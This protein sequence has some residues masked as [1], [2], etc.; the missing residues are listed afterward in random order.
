MTGCA[1]AGNAIVIEDAGGEDAWGMAGATIV[2]GGH[3]IQRL[4]NRG[5][6]I[7]AGFAQFVYHARDSVVE[8]FRPGEG[9]GVVAHATVGGRCGV[10]CYFTRRVSAIV[11]GLTSTSDAAMVEN[12]GLKI[13]YDMT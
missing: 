11:T 6:A 1:V 12:D 9:S 3:M 7:V 10:V 13:T 8:T 4:T 2:G 5:N